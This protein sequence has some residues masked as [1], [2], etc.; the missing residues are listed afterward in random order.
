MTLR[1]VDARRGQLAFR[2]GG[3]KTAAGIVFGLML[4]GLPMGQA[5]ADEVPKLTELSPNGTDACFGRVYDA[6][7]LKAHPK[8]KVARIFFYYGHDPVSH[9]NEEPAPCDT[10]YNGF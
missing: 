10:S 9:P 3:F 6:A 2:I 4:L 5:Q 7:H 8:Q 1:P